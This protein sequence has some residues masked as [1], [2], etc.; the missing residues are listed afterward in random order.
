MAIRMMVS[1]EVFEG[2][3]A[4]G[5]KVEK[6][7][8]YPG[9]EEGLVRHDTKCPHYADFAARL[10][11]EIRMEGLHADC[12][13]GS[14]SEGRCSGPFEALYM[15]TTHEGLVLED[16]GEYNGRDDS[17]F[18]AV[19]WDVEAQTTRRV[20]YASTRGWTYPNSAKADATDEVKAAFLAYC[21]RVRKAERERAEAARLAAVAAEKLEPKKG[22][23]VRVVRG[24]KVAIGTEGVVVWEGVDN[25]GKGRIG[26]K[27]ASGE[28]VFTAAANAEALQGEAEK[29]EAHREEV[30]ASS[31]VWSKGAK[32]RIVRGKSGVGFVGQIFWTKDG[33]WGQRVGVKSGKAVEFTAAANV[34]AINA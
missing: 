14:Y 23:A 6:I 4:S 33:A 7:S 21:E 32:V 1:K 34:E 29:V 2:R 15:E 24:R 28:T 12:L 31:P 9:H 11:N 18:Y 20:E 13:Q 8:D 16:D 10:G 19:V 3:E 25:W 30:R 27:L 26:I 5:R 17:D 22:R